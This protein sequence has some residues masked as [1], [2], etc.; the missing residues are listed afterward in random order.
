MYKFAKLL[1]AIAFAASS[2]LA[3]ASVMT[4]VFSLPATTT[5]TV[6]N[7]F[8]YTH[9]LTDNL[10]PYVP[11]F[12]SISSAMLSIRLMDNGPQNGGLED[13]TFRLNFDGSLLFMGSN[14]TNGNTDYSPLAV[15]SGPLAALS[16]TGKLALTIAAQSGD[17]RF[18]SSTLT[19]NVVEGVVT[20]TGVPEPFSIALLGVGLAGVAASRRKA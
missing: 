11:G 1:G 20:P 8:I 4:D 14:I 7:P 17:F 6:Q 16:S 18:V 2:S 13:F 3:S 5:V 19:A 9:D 12:D 10:P 15:T